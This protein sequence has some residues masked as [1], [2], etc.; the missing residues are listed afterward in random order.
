MKELNYAQKQAQI[1]RLYA[2]AENHE[3]KAR[4]YATKS[5]WHDGQ[6]D[7][8]MERIKILEAELEAGIDG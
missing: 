8:C 3:K 2:C 4:E 1:N 7:D 5:I 6:A